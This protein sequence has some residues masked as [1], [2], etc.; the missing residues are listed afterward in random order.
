MSR[1]TTWQGDGMMV[2]TGFPGASLL[3]DG[4]A[5]GELRVRHDQRDSRDPWFHWSFRLRGA[6]GRRITV[7]FGDGALVGVR[8]P[9]MSLDE[10]RSWRWLDETAADTG[11]IYYARGSHA[12]G[13][14]PTGDTVAEA[15]AALAAVV[16]L[17]ASG[18]MT[19]GKSDWA[20]NQ[21]FVAGGIAVAILS[22][23]CSYTHFKLMRSGQQ[24]R[25]MAEVGG[26]R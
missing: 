13:A 2:E 17:L 9:A 4:I 5:G 18:K 16:V 14:L 23:M 19:T 15:V 25:S 22:A 3:V 11:T 8:G 21:I 6:A 24:A 12:W 26:S 7:R 1:C 20:A 10:G